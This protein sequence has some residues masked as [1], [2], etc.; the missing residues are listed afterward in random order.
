M[1]VEKG[2]KQDNKAEKRTLASQN[3]TLVKLDFS[4]C[5][6][7]P[8]ETCF[9]LDE[10]MYNNTLTELNLSGNFLDDSFAFD[11]ATLL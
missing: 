1:T 6:L 2:G 7:K 10:L 9:L 11:L 3:K 4:N 5:G 8:F